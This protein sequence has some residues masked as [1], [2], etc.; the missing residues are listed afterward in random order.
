MKK[1]HYTKLHETRKGRL[2]LGHITGN[3]ANTCAISRASTRHR[4]TSHKHKATPYRDTQLLN[5]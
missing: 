3:R 5:G 1:E 2:G 4:C